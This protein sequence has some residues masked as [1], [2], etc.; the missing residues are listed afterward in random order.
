MVHIILGIEHRLC[1]KLTALS[2]VQFSSS[3]N[4]CSTLIDNLPGV[5][6]N[7]CGDDNKVT[8]IINRVP[9]GHWY[10]IIEAERLLVHPLQRPATS[11]CVLS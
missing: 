2:S 1:S 3:T 11:T 5:T 7:V 10:H 4:W 8:S 6:V 9:D